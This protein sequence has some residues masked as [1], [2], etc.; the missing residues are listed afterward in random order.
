MSY[1]VYASAGEIMLR[2]DLLKR[3]IE[4][5]G[6]QQTGFGSPYA[7]GKRYLKEKC[8]CSSRSI[9]R[10][11][12]VYPKIIGHDFEEKGGF[13]V[14]YYHK[15]HCA[16]IVSET[17]KFILKEP[18]NAIA[19]I[20]GLIPEKNEYLNY[21]FAYRLSQLRTVVNEDYKGQ[22]IDAARIVEQFDNLHF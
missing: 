3:C 12:K 7:K 4:Y 10:A 18:D 6:T 14:F 5:I 9:K 1:Y 11:I 15:E 21:V 2:N 16:N 20:F 22:G 8:N 13:D 17:I 19:L